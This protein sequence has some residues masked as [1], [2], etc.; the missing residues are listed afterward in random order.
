VT[1]GRLIDSPPENPG[2]R[3]A[4]SRTARRRTTP[5]TPCRFENDSP[6]D[7]PRW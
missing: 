7:N 1:A 5:L 2:W 3:R 6:P 4:G